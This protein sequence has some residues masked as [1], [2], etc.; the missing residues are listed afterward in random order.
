MANN[1]KKIKGV[2]CKNGYWYAGIDGKQKCCGK[3]NKGYNLAKTARM[4]WEVKQYENREVNAG[5][6]VKKVE[7]KNVADLSN[8][9]MEIPSIQQQS[10]YFR[11]IQ[12]CKHLLKYFGNR[13]LN[14]IEST[15]QEKY[16]KFRKNQGAYEGTI[17]LELKVL[18]AVSKG[19]QG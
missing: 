10:S 14:S 4:K 18:R 15:Q 1:H 8:W 7:L 9:Y 19:N 16:R 2:T 12:A 3:G 17:D 5:L 11:K 6:K 13:P